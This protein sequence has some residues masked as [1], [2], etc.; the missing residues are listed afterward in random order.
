MTLS[1]PAKLAVTALAVVHLLVTLWHSAAHGELGIGLPPW[2]LAYAYAVIVIA[3]P[4]AAALVWS[5][6]AGTGLWIFTLAMVGSLLFAGY[7][8]YVLVSPDNIAHLPEGSPE[9]QAHFVDSAA[10]S[11]LLELGSALY[12]AFALGRAARPRQ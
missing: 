11:A 7:H 10:L 1:R 8:H 9:A 12:G 4:L 2:K 5:R 3:P 6:F